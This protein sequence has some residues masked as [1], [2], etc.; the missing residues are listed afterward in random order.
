[1][2]IL[3]MV[4]RFPPAPCGGA[5]MQCWKQA[6]ALAA[7]G[8]EVTVL[9]E[10]LA[11]DSARREIKEGVV[12]RRLG[13]FL[14]VTM[15]IRRW[16]RQVRLKMAPP[17][18]D[19]PDPFS[20]DGALS[21]GRKRRK[22]RWMAPVEWLGHASFILEAGWAA[23]RGR[24]QADVVHVHESHW[25]AGFGHWV[26]EKLG[27]AVFCKEAS[28]KVLLWPAGGDVPGQARWKRRRSRCRFIA[29]TP[30]IRGELEKSGI[31]PAQIVDI[32][33]GV[34]LP[35]T[36]ARPAMNGSAI[37]GGNFTQGSAYKA[38]DVLVQAW[39][40]VQREEPGARL[41]LYGEGDASRWRQ[42]AAQEGCGE[43]VQFCGKTEHLPEK[44]SGAGFLVLP[45]RLE[46]LS[47]VL[48]EAQAAGLPAV[49]S[50]IGGNVAV[51]NHGVNGL[52]VP[53][54]DASAL[55]EACVKLL[56]SP[57]LREKMGQAAR[58]RVARLFCMEKVAEQLESAYRSAQTSPGPDVGP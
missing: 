18:G 15:A 22:F 24:L 40:Q 49:V 32:P 21:I 57:G 26:G 44:F 30:H 36:V 45:S 37:Y 41:F 1:M 25:L 14:P 2:K 55:A 42:L 19:E 11:G 9:T 29:M 58:E 51:V 31:L 23:K 34:V 47:N 39:G 28:A 17:A 5:E 43:S 50:D 33:N 3:M 16:H 48:L 53:V 6:C 13:C 7:R 20:V 38:F 8:H 56:R 12:I 54:G 27:A 46:G 4:L 10:W 52:V 35:E